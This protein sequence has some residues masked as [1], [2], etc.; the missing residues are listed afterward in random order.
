[1]H[2]LLKHLLAQLCLAATLTGAAF[3]AD[4]EKKLTERIDAA[5][6]VVHELMATPDKGV[7]LWV[8]SKATCVLVVPGFKKGAFV[9]GGQYGQGVATC[10]NNHHWSAPAFVQITGASFGLQAGG[11]STDLVLV[12]TNHKS[13]QD[14]LKEK[15][16][17]GGD[18]AASAGP[19]GRNSQAAISA[20]ASAEFLTYSRS[21]GLFAG[22][23]LTGDF[24]NQN[25]EDTTVYY[26]KDISYSD[27]LSGKTPIHSSARE[28]V[29]AV[30][31]LFRE[32]KAEK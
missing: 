1:M 8:A 7:P 25:K 24:I 3:A 4:S 30:S 16:K 22:I 20:L 32:G 15:V 14:M 13:M 17:L 27:I 9:F 19:V 2:K 6:A 21:K 31:Q 23:D 11:Q 28:F 12:G 26:G 5:T 29:N 10:R 18:V